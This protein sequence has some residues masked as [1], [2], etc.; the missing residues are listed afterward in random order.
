LVNSLSNVWLLVYFS[1][2]SAV[3]SLYCKYV[4][5]TFRIIGHLLVHNWSY[6]A[7]AIASGSLLRMHYAAI[8]VFSFTGKML[9]VVR[10]LMCSVSANLMLFI[11]LKKNPC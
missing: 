7:T 11:N 4:H 8:H 9:S 5:F 2:L 6:K 1:H 3:S 10:V